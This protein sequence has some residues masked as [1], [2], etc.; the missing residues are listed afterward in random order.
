[1]TSV[2]TITTTSPSNSSA[3]HIQIPSR[4]G[5]NW[6]LYACLFGTT[7]G[8]TGLMLG[9]PWRSSTRVLR[10]WRGVAVLCLFVGLT[11]CGGGGN[12]P[13]PGGTPQG[14]SQVTVTASSGTSSMTA[15]V[16]LTVQ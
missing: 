5:I 6:P 11:S 3:G 4:P 12:S 10:L 13:S 8:L 7:L 9:L 2:L 1:V 15:T 14:T 16:T